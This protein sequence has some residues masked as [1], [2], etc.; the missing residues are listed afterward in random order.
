MN[1][2]ESNPDRNDKSPLY[3]LVGEANCTIQGY[4]MSQ[5]VIAAPAWMLAI[6]QHKPS[7]VIEI[8]TCK[9]GLSNLISSCT[10]HIGAEF[11]TMDTMNG[12]EKNKYPLYGNASFHQWDCF[13]Y[14]EEIKNWI[15]KPG[16]CFVLC[17]GGNKPREFNLFSDL[18]KTG[19][20]IA[21]HDFLPND[22]PDYTPLYWGCFETHQEY[23]DDAINRNGLVDFEPKWFKWSA[24]CV[25]QKQ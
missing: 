8:G 25:K 18:I 24:W 20:I 17:D 4:E 23:L 13:K 9:G 5:N 14:I 19:D 12:G 22:V 6:L 10:A 11:H 3:H 16:M 21:A 7:M 2:S 1:L 15:R